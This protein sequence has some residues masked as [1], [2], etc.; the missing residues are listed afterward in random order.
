MLFEV[1]SKNRLRARGRVFIIMLLVLIVDIAKKPILPSVFRKIL[2]LVSL[3]K[4]FS[5]GRELGSG[6][7]NYFTSEKYLEPRHAR[8]G[9]N[10]GR[11]KEEKEEN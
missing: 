7:S 1:W 5:T 2:Y 8:K 6:G 11:K 4:R 10:F 9:G 3:L